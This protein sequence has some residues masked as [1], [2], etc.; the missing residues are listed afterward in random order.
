MNKILLI[1]ILTLSVSWTYFSWNY[2]TCS[3]KWFCNDWNKRV[4]IVN[5]NQKVTNE[6]DLEK[7]LK[8]DEIKELDKDSDEDAVLVE[9]IN[10]KDTWAII[11]EEKLVKKEES[12]SDA[13]NPINKDEE[14]TIKKENDIQISEDE[15]DLEENEEQEDDKEVKLKEIE[16]GTKNEDDKIVNLEEKETKKETDLDKWDNIEEEHDLDNQN[17]C[18]DL[19]TKNI[20]L[21][22]KDNDEAQ[23]KKLESF[24]KEKENEDIVVNWVY[25]EEDLEAVKR[26]QLKYRKDILDP[27]GINNPTGYV[28][29][30][31]IKKIN[32]LNCSK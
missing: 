12:L 28:Y 30:T 5:D 25:E 24:L 2:Y 18:L 14:D 26:F 22:S 23:V 7:D 21:L 3:I 1:I 10:K 13:E 29:K 31:T 17:L 9:Y 8:E 15:I 19:I 20:K 4:V 11:R 27:W 16:E 6:E 32:T